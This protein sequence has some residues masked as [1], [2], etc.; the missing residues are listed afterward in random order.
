MANTTEIIACPV[1]GKDMEKV[2]S[3]DN[4]LCI[5]VCTNGCGGIFFDN[6]ELKKVDEE[7][8]NIDFILEAIKDKEFKNTDSQEQ[9]TCPL[10]N[11]I[12]VKN[13]TNFQGG[14]E[15]DECYTCGGIFLNNG[16]LQKI[17]Q[18]YKDENKRKEEFSAFLAK[19]LG[20][21]QLQ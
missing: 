5:D 8:E 14:V 13:H 19:E 10:C 16:E 2:Y 6:R 21:I 4:T 9:L 7:K 12:M 18:E 20:R 17:R 3:K 1:C 11:S 15:I